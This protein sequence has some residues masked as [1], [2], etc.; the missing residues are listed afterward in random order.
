MNKWKTSQ[1]KEMFIQKGKALQDEKLSNFLRM[2]NVSIPRKSFDLIKS[3]ALLLIDQERKLVE[4][5]LNL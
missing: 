4:A 3:Y 1:E 2:L 5:R